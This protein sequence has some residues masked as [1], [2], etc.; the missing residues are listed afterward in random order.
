M[1]EIIGGFALVLFG[2]LL[3]YGFGLYRRRRVLDAK[4]KVLFRALHDELGFIST[5]LPPYGVGQI[6]YLD[7]LRLIVG[8]MLL[9]GE[10]LEY[11]KHS[12][13]LTLLVKLQ[14]AVARYN[15]FV[16]TYNL[17]QTTGRLDDMAHP[18]MYE[19]AYGLHR[20][21]LTARKEVSEQL[22]TG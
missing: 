6:L 16:Q 4:R 19:I 13:L 15:D 18:Q 21:V 2:A 20:N 8:S 17:A 9:D 14:L 11:R 3:A 5:E 10:T 22:P 1:V 7:P 12:A